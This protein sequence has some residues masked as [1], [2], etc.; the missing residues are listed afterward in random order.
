MA[1]IIDNYE[2]KNETTFKIGGIVKKAAFPNSIDELINLLKTK[3]YDIVLGGCSNVLFSSGKINKNILIT[4]DVS[5]YDIM[6]N[7]VKVSCG[8]RG[9]RISREAQKKGLSGFEF[10]IGF[11]G[12]FGGMISMNASAHNQSI[13]DCFMNARVYDINTDK[14][15][16]LNKEQMNFGYRQ[17][18]LS[19]NHYVLIDAEFELKPYDKDKIEELMNR[20]IEF[21]KKRQP[22][23]SYGNAGS[24]FKNP[25]ND[26]AGRLLDLCNLK[27]EKEGGAMI[28]EN[29]AN[30]IINY[31]N[32]TSLD[33]ITL[34]YKMYSKVKERYTIELEPEIKFI[35]DSM[36]QENRLWE[37]MQKNT[38]IIQK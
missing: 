4:K 37:I 25:K 8:T 18:I 27:G 19:D 24:I 10:M 32:A 28:Y 35:G 36:E 21:R 22:S 30:F 6:G 33:V 38:K 31:D 16:T 3:E 29:H 11:P 14:I 17:S 7:T 1:K 20:N 13:S 5:G 34:M 15:I 26:S 9:A 12:T 23:L 2:I